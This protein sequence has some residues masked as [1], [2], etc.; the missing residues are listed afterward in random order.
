MDP[1][2]QFVAAIIGFLNVVSAL[3]QPAF[4]ALGCVV[5]IRALKD[6]R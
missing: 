4:Y 2:G 5:M 6:S 1:V 3:A